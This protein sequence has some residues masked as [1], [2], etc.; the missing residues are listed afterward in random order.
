MSLMSLPAHLYLHH[1]FKGLQIWTN[2]DWNMS[3]FH[4]RS[5][6]LIFIGVNGKTVIIFYFS[7]SNIIEKINI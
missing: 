1:V 3:D 5:D 6:P 4:R 2:R 7:E